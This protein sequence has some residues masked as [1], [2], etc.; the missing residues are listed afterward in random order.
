ME[1]QRGCV[2]EPR[3]YNQ[4]V[5]ELR[6]RVRQF[7]RRVQVLSPRFC[8]LYP[9]LMLCLC[10]PGNDVR[11]SCGSEKDARSSLEPC[12]L[13]AS[14]CRMKDKT[15]SRRAWAVR[16]ELLMNFLLPLWVA[17][18]VFPL[19]PSQMGE[20]GLEGKRNGVQGLEQRRSL[21]SKPSDQGDFLS[22]LFQ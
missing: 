5:G 19:L 3:S 8:T 11:L 17:C 21:V 6:F 12:Y 2:A 20:G 7:Y 10:S 22:G 15:E 1:A 18:P 9:W 16:R 4:T 13:W 14:G